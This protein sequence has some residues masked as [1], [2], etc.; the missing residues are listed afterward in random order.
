MDQE[1]VKKAGRQSLALILPR[2]QVN[3]HAEQAGQGLLLIDPKLPP[4]CEMAAGQGRAA[5]LKAIEAAAERFQG[6]H[7]RI[8]IKVISKMQPPPHQSQCIG[9][10][11]HCIIETFV[12]AALAA[13]GM[14]L[15]AD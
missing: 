15:V 10:N 5:G 11:G 13:G 1:R 4:L 9:A 8:F 2:L 14:I 7:V 12:A 3:A 6:I